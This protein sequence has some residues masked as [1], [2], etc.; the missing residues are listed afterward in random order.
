MVIFH[1]HYL[2]GVSPSSEA[3][4]ADLLM[5][6]FSYTFFSSFCLK[7]AYYAV[8]VLHFVFLTLGEGLLLLII[9]LTL[10][11]FKDNLD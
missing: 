8:Q 4:L 10:V 3:H 7:M 5:L 1:C 2:S 6:F 11:I 9:W